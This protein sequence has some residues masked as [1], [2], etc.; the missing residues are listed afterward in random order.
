MAVM[1]YR[2]NS[3]NSIM[4]IQMN[5]VPSYSEIGRKQHKFT[6]IVVIKIFAISLPSQPFLA[7]TLDFT[8]F[9]TLASIHCPSLSAMFNSLCSS[10]NQELFEKHL[11]NKSSHYEKYGRFKGSHHVQSP[12][13]WTPFTVS[14]DEW[15]TK[16]DTGKS[17]KNALHLLRYAKR[18]LE[19][20]SDSEKIKLVALAVIELCWSE[21]IS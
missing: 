14:K 8:S 2:L 9:F 19:A 16:E 5:L 3:K 10:T 11:C 12:N 17:L 13:Y 7:A 20:T 1:V 18:H 4:T 15:N 6:W 21:G